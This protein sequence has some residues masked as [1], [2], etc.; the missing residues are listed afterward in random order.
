MRR[1]PVRSFN[2]PLW[3]LAGYISIQVSLPSC[4]ISASFLV[5]LPVPHTL[6]LVSVVICIFLCS[7]CLFPVS[8]V[9]GTGVRL[10]TWAR[11]PDGACT[12]KRCL[13]IKA[14]QASHGDLD[15]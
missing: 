15:R 13:L 8:L 9:T 1:W 2:P 11:V 14:L 4:L 5:F 7:H 10:F 6:C 12:A 3:L